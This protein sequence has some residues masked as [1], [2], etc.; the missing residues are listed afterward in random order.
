MTDRQTDRDRQTEAETERES[1]SLVWKRT[2]GWEGV[3]AMLN[4][5]LVPAEIAQIAGSFLRDAISSRHFRSVSKGHSH[6]RGVLRIGVVVYGWYSKPR[7]YIGRRSTLHSLETQVYTSVIRN[8]D[9][10]FS[11]QKGRSTLQLL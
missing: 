4:G 10:H 9:L 2:G 8:A 6:R 5:S 7:K 1:V 11:Y 3:N